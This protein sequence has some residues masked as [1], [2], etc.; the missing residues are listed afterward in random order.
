V[1]VGPPPANASGVIPLLWRCVLFLLLPWAALAD[2]IVF[3]R[4]EF[5]PSQ[6]PI[7]DQRAMI[8][9]ADGVERLVIETSFAGPGTNFAWVVPLPAVAEIEEATPGLFP[10]LTRIFLPAVDLEGDRWFVGFG[11]LAMGCWAV[12]RRDRLA[13]KHQ[14]W[15]TLAAFAWGMVW[16]NHVLDFAVALLGTLLLLVVSADLRRRLDPTAKSDLMALILLS[17]TLLLVGGILLPALGP[18]GT[19]GIGSGDT[20]GNGVE[21]LTR[22]KTKSFEVEVVAG[23]NSA[24]LTDWLRNRGYAASREVVPVIS[25]YVRQGWVFAATQ[26]LGDEAGAT[27]A[28]PSISFRFAAA[29]PVYPMALTGVGSHG[30]KVELFVFG[31]EQASA[32]GWKAVRSQPL[33]LIETVVGNPRI[34]PISWLATGHPLLRKWIGPDTRGTLLRASLTPSEMQRDV[35]LEWAGTNSFGGLMPSSRTVGVRALNYGAWVA[36]IFAG[37][38][39]A[40]KRSVS[41]GSAMRCWHLG[42]VAGGIFAVLLWSTSPAVAIRPGSGPRRGHTT[43]QDLQR[44]ALEMRRRLNVKH[45]SD[46]EY[47]EALGRYFTT[48]ATN[49]FTGQLMREGDAPGDFAVH[50]DER[51]DWSVFWIDAGGSEVRLF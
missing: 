8:H 34:R 44:D 41:S 25:N 19:R 40:L 14:I 47:A 26:L 22:A 13:S 45:L 31:P 28:T 4:G 38:A 39:L 30:L 42:W 23:T 29:E 51:G 18:A 17:M 15:L 2:G 35:R 1:T 12:L 7:P 50:E 36:A 33:G 32:P 9:W 5:D 46:R 24:A 27:N 49:L 43:F 10:T 3:P 6:V 11:W 16:A 20:A 21:V 48:A 37:V